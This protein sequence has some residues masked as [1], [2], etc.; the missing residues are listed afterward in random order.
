[1]DEIVRVAQTVQADLIR[2]RPQAPGELDRTLEARRLGT[3]EP[4]RSRAQQPADGHH[5]LMW[6]A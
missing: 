6:S 4:D 2:S 3:T 1:V 5:A